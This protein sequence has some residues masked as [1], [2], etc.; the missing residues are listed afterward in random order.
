[1]KTLSDVVTIVKGHPDFANAG[2]LLCH[3]GVVRATSRDGRPVSG[4]RVSVN[5]ERLAAMLASHRKR[6]GI[7]DIQVD[8]AEDTDLSVGEDVMV[9][10]VA[11]DVRENVI[12]VLTETLDAVKMTVT[13]KTEYFVSE[14]MS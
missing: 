13:R 7:V 14:K 10:V 12:P 8:I 2:M 4:L 3:N 6:P 1:M 5:H 11:G 9:L